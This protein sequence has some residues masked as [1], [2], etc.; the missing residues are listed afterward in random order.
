MP[1]QSV[2][3]VNLKNKP[4]FNFFKIAEYIKHG[5]Q[6]KNVRKIF[7]FVHY[8][9]YENEKIKELTAAIEEEKIVLPQ[10]Y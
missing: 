3:H 8:D 9:E 2:T 10:K 6:K 1:F 4:I 5:K 7:H